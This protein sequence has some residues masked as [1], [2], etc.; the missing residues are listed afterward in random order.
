MLLAAP[1]A[2]N[3]SLWIA[4]TAS[5]RYPSLD[6]DLSVDVAIVGGGI[7][8]LTAAHLLKQAGLTVAVVEA[9]RIAEGETGFTTAHLTEAIDARYHTLKKDFGL[10]G[11]RMAAEAS[12]AAIDFIER[13][14]TALGIDCGFRRLDGFLYSET[15]D[16]LDELRE[17]ADAAREA[18]V[19]AS[20][21]DDVPLPFATGG[22]RFAQQAEFHP[23]R[24]L[25][26]IAES[27]AGNGSHIFE[28]TR[29]LGVHDGEPCRVETASGV[30]SAKAVFVA[31]NVPV[32]NK[33]FLQTKIPAYRTYAMAM[34]V[35]SET[36][37]RG[38]F[39][40]TA[41]PYHYTRWQSTDEGTFLIVGGKDH[42]TGDVED[43]ESHYGSL[44]DYI[45]NHFEIDTI[46][47][48]WSGQIIEPLDGLPYIGRNS[49]SKNVYVATGFAGQGMTFGTVS[50]MLVADLIQGREHRWRGLFDPTRI[51]PIA[52]AVDFVTENIDFPKHLV[53]DRL[54]SLDVEGHSLDDVGAGEG[55]ILKLDG[56]KV[57]VSRDET[58][59]VIALSPVCT[60]MGCDVHWNNAERS[61]DCPCHGSRFAP[62]GD[63]LNG[64]AVD[65]LKPAEIDEV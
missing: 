12:R 19:S 14:A 47:Y 63:V 33:L 11:A 41:D 55:K 40:D 25:L 54:T 26:P 46:A 20:Y 30:I 42:K 7:A 31:A 53:P 39:W 15:G 38:L 59:R 23:R 60:H 6:R 56:R 8:G 44:E 58:G 50:G 21:T 18:G 17:E 35:S 64:P 22:V 48:R 65:P 57:A 1:C 29:V 4:T 43:T 28:N 45:R 61:W 34:K 24:Y 62:S 5:T 32:N 37:L 13:N 16:D 27:I 2:M 9:L 51:K 49:I 3:E 36:D 10:D 52:S